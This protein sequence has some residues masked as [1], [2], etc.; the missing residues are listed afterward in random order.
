[1]KRLA[2]VLRHFI[3]AAA[4]DVKVV[5]GS[6]DQSLVG[7]LLPLA[8][9]VPLVA[10]SASPLEM[11]I[12]PDQLPVNEKSLVVGFRRNRRRR[13]RSPFPFFGREGRRLAQGFQ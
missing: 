5:G 10:G 6:F 9:F 1:M 11:R 3:V 13:T 2:V 12:L 4:A 8:R 7:V